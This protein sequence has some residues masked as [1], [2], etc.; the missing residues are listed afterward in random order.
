FIYA[1]FFGIAW[2]LVCAAIG[3]TVAGTSPEGVGDGA[4]IY[5]MNTFLPAGLFGLVLAALIGII[6]SSW[7]SLLNCASVSFTVDIIQP[8]Y[9]TELTS[10]KSLILTK[11]LNVVIGL[12]A[13]LFALAVPGIV[14]ALMYCYTLWAPTVVLP[15]ALAIIL[16]KVNPYAGLAAIVSGGLATAVWEWSL[17]TPYGVPSLL[18]GVLFNQLAFWFVTF[19]IRN[20]PER[21]L[22][23]TTVPNILEET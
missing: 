4:F 14:E 20:R 3:I 12:A 21:G 6:L 9:K 7:D 18:V 10:R 15:L 11:L 16:P 23:G 8:F 5:A 17:D 22:F 2:F 13:I 1:A 19:S